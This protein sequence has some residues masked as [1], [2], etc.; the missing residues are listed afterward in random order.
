MTMRAEFAVVLLAL[1][2]SSSAASGGS[3]PDHCAI[4]PI[5][6]GP[7]L[8]RQC[9]RGSPTDVSDFWSSSPLQVL[10]IEQRLPE[11]LRKSGHKIKLSDSRRQ[12][13]GVTSH[14]KKL[15]YLNA[16]PASALDISE[17]T[18]WQTTALTVCD[19]GDVFWGVEFYPA[20]N[21]FHNIQFN[22]VA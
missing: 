17:H 13:V 12:Y 21:T 7:A 14:G 11:L 15:I 1:L 18:N 2:V 20:D 16:F 8:I 19:G 22:G 10:A 4:L 9:S 6:Q 5:S 3:L